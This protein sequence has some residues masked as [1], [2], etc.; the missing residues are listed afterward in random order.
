VY[1]QVQGSRLQP[2]PV[3]LKIQP[4]SE[5]QWAEVVDALAAEAQYAAT[6]LTGAM[7]E[8]IEQ[9]FKRVGVPLFPQ[10]GHDIDM[11]CGCPD[12]AVPCKHIA[13]VYYLLAEQFDHDPFLLFALRGLDRDG[14]LAALRERR[15][16]EDEAEVTPP[17]REVAPPLDADLDHFYG[18]AS[19]L[20]AITIAPPAVDGAMVRRFGPPPGET[21]AALRS[22]YALM[23]AEVLRQ[24]GDDAAEPNDGSV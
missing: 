3:T 1:A 21:E 2:Y 20:P 5:A 24:I 14:L 22:L 10:R 16:G 17:A 19:T 23:T 12:V 7:P 4:L 15:G 6:L 18:A 9:V 11:R 13:A 8:D